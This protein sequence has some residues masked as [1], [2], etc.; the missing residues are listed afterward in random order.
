MAEC[1]VWRADSADASDVAALLIEFRDWAGSSTP[2]DDCMRRSVELLMQEPG[3]AFLLATADRDL[4]PAAVCQLRFRHSVWTG[5][6]DCWLEDL[7]VQ[8]AARSL[9]LGRRL[10]TAAC[11]EARRRRCGRIELDVNDENRPAMS[12]YGSLGFSPR[13]K[14]MGSEASRDLLMGLRL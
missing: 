11:E 8:A 12:L 1:R 6:D 2:P 14:R 4:P 13:S 7:Y 3:T 10:L 5:V 9:G